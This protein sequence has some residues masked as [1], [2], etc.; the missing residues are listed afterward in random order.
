VAFVLDTAIAFQN[1]LGFAA[2][3]DAVLL[4]FR[5]VLLRA[6]P[7]ARSKYAMPVYLFPSQVLPSRSG[8]A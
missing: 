5:Q 7:P 2:E 4:F 6:V 8:C 3:A 1:W